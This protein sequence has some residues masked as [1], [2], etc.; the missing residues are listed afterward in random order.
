MPRALA[1]AWILPEMREGRG[2]IEAALHGGPELPRLISS[3]T[4]AA[5]CTATLRFGATAATRSSDGRPPRP[6]ADSSTW[7]SPIT[8]P[9]WVGDRVDGRRAGQQWIELIHRLNAAGGPV[10]GAQGGSS[11]TS[12]PTARSTY[13]DELLARLDLVIAS[14]HSG[15]RWGAATDHRPG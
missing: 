2:E 15:F 14:V 4:C 10:R 8:R 6:G 13:T 7:R 12:S 11:S 1:I 3:R 5:T 9:R